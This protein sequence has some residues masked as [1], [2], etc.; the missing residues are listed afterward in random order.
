MI[1]CEMDFK[2]GKN[3]TAT[4]TSEEDFARQAC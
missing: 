1:C 2:L 4:E 3:P